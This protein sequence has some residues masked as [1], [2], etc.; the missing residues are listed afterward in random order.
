MYIVYSGRNYY[1]PFTDRAEAYRWGIDKFGRDSFI[2]I[3]L[4]KR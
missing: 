2:V 3:P 1:G 4:Y